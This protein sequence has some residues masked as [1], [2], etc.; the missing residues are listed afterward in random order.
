LPAVVY[1]TTQWNSISPNVFS[2]DLQ[3][4]NDVNITSLQFNNDNPSTAYTEAENA[5]S[6]RNNAPAAF[7]SQYRLVTADDYKNFITSTFG[8]IIQDATV[9]SNNDYVN[10]HL[11]Y[12][13][14]IGLTKPNQDNRVLYNQVA[15]ST[16]CN[17]NNVYI[18]VLPKST[19]SN[20]VNYINYLTPTQKSLITNAAISKKTLT[21]DIIV[22]DPVYKAVTVGYDASNSTDVNT[23]ISQSRLVV[24]LQRNAKI[25]T[26]LLQNKITGIVQ[27]FFN[28]TNLTLGY[29]IDLVNL[30]AQIESIQGV[31]Q[32]YTQRV[33]TGDI[34]QGVSL[35]VWNPAYPNNDITIANKN[36]QL[37]LFQALYFNNINDFSNRIVIS[38]DVSQ[39]TSV[40]NI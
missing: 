1:N 27:N 21:S 34:V 16:S 22:M 38:A 39:D 40:I 17:F 24:T 29:N 7:K 12:L 30:T 32:V 31:D 4:L 13:Y 5:D 26:Q 20:V 3:Y 23:I 11:R 15:F 19:N 9:Y 18:Y 36:Y 2:T 37:L 35:V 14:N 28:P 6:I 8:N 25:S 10:N 33:D